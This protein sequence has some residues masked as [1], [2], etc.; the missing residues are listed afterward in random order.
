MIN[1][2]NLYIANLI[3]TYEVIHIYDLEESFN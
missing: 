2:Y 3:G 1:S